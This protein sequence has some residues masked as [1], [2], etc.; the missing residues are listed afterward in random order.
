M[1]E[2]AAFSWPSLTC[3]VFVIIVT[4]PCPSRPSVHSSRQAGP[5]SCLI[6]PGKQILVCSWRTRCRHHYHIKSTLT[7]FLH[8]HKGIA[9]NFLSQ[10]FCPWSSFVA[11]IFHST[12]SLL[13]TDDAS[14]AGHH[15]VDQRT[16]KCYR[17]RIMI[18]VLLLQICP[19]RLKSND[20]DDDAAAAAP[21]HKGLSF[22]MDAYPVVVA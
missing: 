3:S 4:C 18:F 22:A 16:W 17:K 21:V 7:Y 2:A 12:C 8:G 10:L 14:P 20:M 1:R 5:G 15:R 13:V 9:C 6:C 11:D 19:S